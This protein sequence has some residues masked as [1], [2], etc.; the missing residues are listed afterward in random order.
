MAYPSRVGEEVGA[1]PEA[2]ER[3][4]A[5]KN[6]ASGSIAEGAMGEKEDRFFKATASPNREV[7]SLQALR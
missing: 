6:F 5:S 4:C 2:K 1:Q 7:I 3:F